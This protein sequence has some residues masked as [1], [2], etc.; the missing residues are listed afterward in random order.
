VTAVWTDFGGV[1]TA[2]IWQ[3]MNRLCGRLGL[4][5]ATL[6]TAIWKVTEQF[7]AT[8]LMEPLDTPLVTEQEW[9]RRV[10]RA[11]AEDTGDMVELTSLGE[12]WFDGREANAAWVGTLQRLRRQGTFVGMLSNMPPAWDVYWRRMTPPREHFDDVVMSFEVGYRKP[13]R[14]IFDLA[15]RRAGVDGIDCVLVDDMEKN[16]E[17]AVAAGWRAIHFT[18]AGTAEAEL[19]HLLRGGHG[20]S[21]APSTRP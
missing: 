14:E 8:D 6:A 10:K 12:M 9:L 2:P 20:F 1:L 17:G 7:G 16:C 11:L 15:A 21:P 19:E 4:A 5:P 3:T 13:R 18:D